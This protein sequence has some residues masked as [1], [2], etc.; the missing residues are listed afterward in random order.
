MVVAL[1]TEVSQ[2]D[3]KKRFNSYLVESNAMKQTANIQLQAA[4]SAFGYRMPGK[5]MHRTL[6]NSGRVHGS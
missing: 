1:I 2:E 6:H 4:I 3:I 5:H